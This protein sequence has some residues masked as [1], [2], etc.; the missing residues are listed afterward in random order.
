MS[1]LKETKAPSCG[2]SN[3]TPTGSIFLKE[4]KGQGAL[5][6][7]L[8]IGAAILIAAV[9]IGVLIK[10]SSAAKDDINDTQ[11]VYDDQ[12]NKATKD[13]NLDGSVVE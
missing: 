6:Y 4:K 5:E 7:L 11:Q 1:F 2:F 13:F 9:V 3:K 10:T 8:I 12:I